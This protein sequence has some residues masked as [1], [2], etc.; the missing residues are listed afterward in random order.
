MG[1][2]VWVLKLVY[3]APKRHVYVTASCNCHLWYASVWYLQAFFSFFKILIFWI[4]RRAKEQKNGPKWQKN[5]SRDIHNMILIYDTHVS[6]DNISRCFIHFFQISYLSKH[7][8]YD[9]L[10][11]CT[12]LKWWHIEMLFSF[13]QNFGF[14]GKRAKN[15]PKLTLYLRNCTSYNC[16]FCYTCKMMIKIRVFRVFQSSSINAK[17]NSEVCPTFFTCVW[18]F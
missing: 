10:F 12:T 4:V 9:R 18:F 17:R 3:W 14:Q 5:I 8:S 16:G 15:G 7:T 6:K 11:C 13:F 1:T 2:R